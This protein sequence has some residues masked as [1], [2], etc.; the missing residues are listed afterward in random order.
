MHEGD[1][2]NNIV[3]PKTSKPNIMLNSQLLATS[4]Q[5]MGSS[6][7]TV[8]LSV[9]FPKLIPIKTVRSSVPLNTVFQ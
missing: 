3:M 6:T 2:I 8:N 1:V 9:N 4:G 7:L 5:K